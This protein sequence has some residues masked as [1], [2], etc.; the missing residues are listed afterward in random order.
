MVNWLTPANLP[1][2]SRSTF[3]VQPPQG[4]VIVCELNTTR[5]NAFQVLRQQLHAKCG[6]PLNFQCIY[7][8]NRLIKDCDVLQTIPSGSFLTMNIGLLGGSSECDVC[9]EESQYFCPQ[10]KQH[11][12]SDCNTKVHRHPKRLNHTPSK[13]DSQSASSQYE[14]SSSSEYDMEIS[15]SL[16]S[17]FI[18][19]E[20]IAVLAEKFKL[21]SFKPFQRRIIDATI[22]GEDTLV[23]YPTGSG[24]SLCYQFPPVYMNKKAI[25]V[26]PTISLMQDQVAKLNCLGLKAVYLGSAQ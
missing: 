10:C 20:L 15:P 7:H 4:S 14:A 12:C 6:I 18:D 5:E 3:Y 23:L 1:T 17:S 11:L 8:A 25:I 19:A 13:C 16:E 9:F 24:K 26:T 21:T 22:A 2:E